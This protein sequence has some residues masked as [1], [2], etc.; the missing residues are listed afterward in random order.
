L[1]DQARKE[2]RG[3]IDSYQHRPHPGLALPH[4]AEVAATWRLDP[5]A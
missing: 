1:L 2:I 4:P 3:Y 5:D